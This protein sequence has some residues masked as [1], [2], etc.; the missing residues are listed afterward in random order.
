MIDAI[1]ELIRRL[2]RRIDGQCPGNPLWTLLERGQYALTT[3]R[4]ER[5]R[6]A[7]PTPV[8]V[9]EHCRESSLH[10]R[11]ASEAHAL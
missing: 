8:S 10:I 3:D 5:T 11:S 4:Y 9:A 1:L 2:T 7:C 6:D